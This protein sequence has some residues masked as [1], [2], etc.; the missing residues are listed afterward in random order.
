MTNELVRL[1]AAAIS[2]KQ[3]VNIIA[4]NVSATSSITDFYLVCSGLSAPHLKALSDETRFVLK[5]Q[6]INCWR[7]SGRPGSGW[8]VADYIDFIIHF[9][10][11]DTRA[12][13]DI[14]RLWQS[15]PT[16]DLNLPRIVKPD[17]V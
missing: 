8:I 15:A 17:M 11:K 16:F 3:G 12:Y 10:K 13:Y 7:T 14:D 2:D 6:G 9:F 4:Y 5:N 1:A